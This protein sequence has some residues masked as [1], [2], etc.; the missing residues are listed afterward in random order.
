MG[1]GRGFYALLMYTKFMYIDSYAIIVQQDGDGGDSLHREG[2]YAFG[3]WLMLQRNGKLAL[4]EVPERRDTEKIISKFEVEPGIYVRHPDPRKWYSNPNTTSRD[5]VVPLLA[6]CA[7]YKDYPRL[8]RFLKA[9]AKR[10]FFMQNIQRAG[11]VP[12]KWKMP[13]TVL[14]HLSLFIRAGGVYTDPLYPLLLVTDTVDFVGTLL[15]LFPLHFEQTA[16][17]FRSKE[18]RDVDD[19]NTIIS[20]LLAVH[21]KPTPVS[22]VDRQVYALSRRWNYGNTKLGELNPVMGALA[23]YHRAENRGNPEMAELY[24]SEIEEY[25]APHRP[26]EA[27]AGLRG[28]EVQP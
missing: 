8:W 3:K 28:L 22:W 26:T 24:R 13:D 12:K 6:Y 15:Q 11:D 21:F 7:A 14:G 16:K 18:P 1:L 17:R 20:H 4:L 23:W 5:Q 9:V 19:N 27:L 2:M 10:G 25:F